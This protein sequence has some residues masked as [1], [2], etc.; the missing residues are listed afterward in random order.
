MN[1]ARSNTSKLASSSLLV[2]VLAATVKATAATALMDAKI[3]HAMW[4]NCVSDGTMEC[5]DRT[6][7]T[8][9]IS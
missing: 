4:D 1:G 7:T 5:D 9:A 8:T 2:T 3:M 6:H